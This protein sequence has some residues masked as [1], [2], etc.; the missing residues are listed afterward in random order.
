MTRWV[1]WLALAAVA[2]GAAPQAGSAEQA[3][4]FRGEVAA[5]ASYKAR[6]RGLPAGAELSVEVSVSGPLAVALVDSA[7]AA[8]AEDGALFSATAD[9]RLAFQLRL[10]RTTDYYLVLDNAEGATAQR[11]SARLVARATAAGGEAVVRAAEEKLAGLGAALAGIFAI[12]DLRFAIEPCGEPNAFARGDLVV[13]CA[14]LGPF[15]AAR[16]ADRNAAGDALFFI[17]LHEA[18]HVL[19]RQ[20]NHPGHAD[21]A[22]VDEFAAVLLTLFG[23]AERGRAA[24]ALMAGRDPEAEDAAKRRT[25]DGRPLSVERARILERHLDDPELVRRWQK[26]LVPRLRTRALELMDDATAAFESRAIEEE[27]AARRWPHTDSNLE[28][29]D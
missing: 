18:G 24:A 7:G 27:L 19:L 13:L 11:F 15:L 12:D 17:L 22:T 16:S 5:G 3:V 8:A 28:P 23:Q 6:L 10:P 25:G 20:W 4:S 21:E 9:G 29:A 1:F 14:E 2:I 26:V